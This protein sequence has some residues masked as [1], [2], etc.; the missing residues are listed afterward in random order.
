MANKYFKRNKCPISILLV[1]IYIFSAFGSAESASGKIRTSLRQLETIVIIYA[2][3][4]SFDNLYGLYPGA[5]GIFRDAEGKPVQQESFRQLDRNG[6]TPLEHLPPVWNASTASAGE[7]SFIAKLPNA[8]F[9]IDAPPGSIPGIKPDKATPDL[10]HRFYNNQMQINRGKNNMFAAWS[11][12]GGLSMGYYDGSSM[13][14]WKL[15]KEYT[16]ADNFFM[17]AFGGSFLNHFW[18]ISAQTPYFPD[19]PAELKSCIEPNG[20]LS[21]TRN[22]P[23]SAMTGAPEYVADKP[24]TPDGYA[25]NTMQPPYQPSGIPPAPGGNPALADASKNPL[26]PQNYRTIGDELSDKGI[27]WIWYAGAWNE[28]LRDRS[29]ISRAGT[30]N[31]QTHHQPFNYFKRFDPATPEGA[32]E[33]ERHLKDFS[34]MQ[35]AIRKGIL[36]PVVFYIPQ[37][38]VNQ[39]AGYSTVMA[40]DAH[41]ADVVHSLQKSPQ[42]KK[43]AIIVTY[44]ENGGF[45]DHVPPPAGD[46]WGPGIRIPAIVISPYA[47]KHYVDH[48]GY[49]T[50]SIL[51]FLT[52]RFGLK[53]LMGVRNNAGDL[54]NAFSFA[55]SR[56]RKILP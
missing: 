18:L 19:A 56:K 39:H 2:E 49:D 42:W 16:L 25:V 34:D 15:A 12:A 13:Q 23:A 36:P 1:V 5:N 27:D 26:P 41:I 43:M 37:G 4:R 33:R 28:A 21:L 8:P 40:G 50:T 48:T 35:E 20:S 47:R 22:S 46:R 7:L 14:M 17:S 44:D 24:L 3:N 55:K 51:K 52:I 45:W 29:V 10:A 9:R 6:A 38:S 32:A 54:T 31:F 30:S 53:P 11:D